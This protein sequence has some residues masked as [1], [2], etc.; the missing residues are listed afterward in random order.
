M[1]RSVLGR[2]LLAAAILSLSLVSMTYAAKAADGSEIQPNFVP[3][4]P[5]KIYV[6]D[7][8]YSRYDGVGGA[9]STGHGCV[10]PCTTSIS[11]TYTWSNSWGA[12]IT[13]KKDP[14]TAAVKYDVTAS[15]STTYT[16]SF[17]V[18]AGRTGVIYYKDYFHVQLLHVHTYWYQT[19]Q[20]PYGFQY[21]TAWAEQWYQ[22][23]FYLVLS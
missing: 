6:V 7:N 1:R 18:P 16:N 4:P 2:A 17:P 13:F 15:S 5:V 9:T 20:P 8:I 12:S 10:G 22:R 3:P 21:G 11:E 23:I 19:G 14:I